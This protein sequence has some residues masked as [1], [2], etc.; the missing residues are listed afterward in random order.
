MTFQ[1][2]KRNITAT[3]VDIW[4]VNKV[5]KKVIFKESKMFYGRIGKKEEL[6]IVSPIY[7]KIKQIERVSYSFKN[8]KTL[9]LSQLV[10][11]VV[12]GARQ[13]ETLLFGEN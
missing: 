7:W 1:M 2:S 11:D 12:L 4:K 8:A 5:L 10:V 13:M 6:Q 3:I 9:I